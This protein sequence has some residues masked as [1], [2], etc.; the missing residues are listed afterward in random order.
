[1]FGTSD[2]DLMQSLNAMAT[3]ALQRNFGNRPQAREDMAVAIKNDRRFD[4][5]NASVLA[6]RYEE[7]RNCGAALKLDDPRLRARSSPAL[8]ARRLLVSTHRETQARTVGSR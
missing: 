8:I 6:R 1:M 5:F 3:E 4:R 2:H 7:A